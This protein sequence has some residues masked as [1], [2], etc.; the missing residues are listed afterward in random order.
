M[1]MFWAPLEAKLGFLL[2]RIC[3]DNHMAQIDAYAMCACTLDALNQPREDCTAECAAALAAQAIK[4][5]ILQP[6]FQDNKQPARKKRKRAS[7]DPAQLHKRRG[8]TTE[9]HIQTQRQGRWACNP[10]SATGE[11]TKKQA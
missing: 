6:Q 2:K 11:P 3:I 4:A 8:P 10:A 7:L 5:A 1:V 9:R